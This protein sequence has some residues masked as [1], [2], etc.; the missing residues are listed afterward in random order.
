MKP[1]EKTIL[2]PIA[3]MTFVL[4]TS[5]R[6]WLCAIAALLLLAFTVLAE[7]EPYHEAD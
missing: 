4:A 5:E 7:T 2:I 3:L 1:H 6:L